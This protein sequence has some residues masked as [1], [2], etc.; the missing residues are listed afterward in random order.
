MP[1]IEDFDARYLLGVDAMDVT[2][3]EFVGLVNRLA[4]SDNAGFA[5]GFPELVAHTREHFAGEDRLMEACGFPAIAEHR[6]EHARVLGDLERLASKVVSGRARLARA[7]V[8]EQLPSWFD[9][10]A[11]TMD[12]ALAA[13]IKGSVRVAAPLAG[14]GLDKTGSTG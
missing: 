10:H 3:R 5:A 4:A 9:L 7:Y 6:A 13:R 2:H 14:G 12:S 1:I 11:A 8:V